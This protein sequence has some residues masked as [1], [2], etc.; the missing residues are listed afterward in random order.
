MPNWSFTEICINAK[1]EVIDELLKSVVVTQDYID[2]IEQENAT[3]SDEFKTHYEK[4]GEVDFNILIPKPHY[5]FNNKSDGENNWFDWNCENWGTKWNAC[6]DYV[7]RQSDEDVT[8]SFMT[9]WS[10]PINWLYALA[11]KAKEVGVKYMRG[12]ATNA[13]D[14]YIYY[15]FKLN[16]MSCNLQFRERHDPEVEKERLKEL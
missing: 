13:Y 6:D 16:L 4:I 1:K 10:C 15:K 8:I 9:A 3:L 12:V 2:K 11:K 5:I 7:E 14:P